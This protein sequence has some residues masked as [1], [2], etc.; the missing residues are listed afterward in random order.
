MPLYIAFI[1]LTKTFDLVIREGLFAILLKIR[2]PPS[3]FN[4]VK[5]FHTNTK[6]TFQYYDK[7]PESFTTKREVK[8]GCVLAPKLFGIF[9]SMLLKR[10][11]YSSTVRFKLHTRPDGCL[12]NPARLNAKSKIKNTHVAEYLA[13]NMQLR[14]LLKI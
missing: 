2:Y 8:Q 11:L 14:I 1:D 4:I 6:A 12:F 10:V 5:S 3:L 13:A 9:F 7:V